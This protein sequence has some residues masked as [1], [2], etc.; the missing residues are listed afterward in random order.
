MN[1]SVTTL[2]VGIVALSVSGGWAGVA[3]V[4]ALA[5]VEGL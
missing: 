1:A 2:G 5:H 4:P 3:H